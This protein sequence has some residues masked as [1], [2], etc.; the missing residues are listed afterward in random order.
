LDY[1]TFGHD[2]SYNGLEKRQV[3]MMKERE[4]T[5]TKISNDFL[6]IMIHILKTTPETLLGV[7]EHALKQLMIETGAN[8]VY[9]KTK[10]M[11]LSHSRTQFNPFVSDQ[12]TP[13]IQEIKSPVVYNLNDS[14]LN[15]LLPLVSDVMKQRYTESWA[16]IPFGE[17]CFLS[18]ESSSLFLED[19][20]VLMLGMYFV[21]A[22]ESKLKT[23]DLQHKIEKTI[24]AKSEF[25]ANMSHEIRTPLSGIYNAFYL[26]N[27][28]GLSHEQLEYVNNGMLSVD[29]LSSMIDDVLDYATIESGSMNVNPTLFDLE[30]EMVRIHQNYKSLSEDKK[31]N[32][33]FDFDYRLNNTWLGD[34]V[35]I[36][37][38]V[39]HLLDNAIKY[40]HTGEIELKI[41][42]K[43]EQE[44]LTWIMI[45]IR[46][47]GIG[48]PSEAL[49]RI[50]DAFVQLDSSESKSYQGTGLGLS[51]ATQLTFLLNGKIEVQSALNQGSQFDVSLPLIAQVQTLYPMTSGMKALVVS[52]NKKRS[53][54]TKALESMGITCFNLNNLHQH[55]VDFIVDED[56]QAQ[57]M[58]L[59]DLK[60][61][62]GKPSVLSLALFVDNQSQMKDIDIIFEW[63]ISRSSIQQKINNRFN[64][65]QKNLLEDNY[66][67]NLRGHA[68]L[69]DD[70]RLNRVALQSIL[71][72]QGIRSTSAD[73]GLKAIEIMKKESF[74]IIFMDIQMPHMDGLETTRR[75]RNLGTSYEK[76]PIIAITANQ[77]FKDY[78]L[79][80][81]T[82]INDVLFKPIRMD[83]LGQV[84]RKYIP[85]E[86]GIQIPDE[87]IV[88]DEIEFDDRFDGSD[89]IA[90]EVMET[91][92]DEYPKDL[93]NIRKSI[94]SGIAQQIYE[95]T[96][97][98]K[99]SCAY[100][101]GKRAVWLLNQMTTLSKKSK[102]ESM[103]MLFDLLEQEIEALI[104]S[105]RNK[106]V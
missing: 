71:L 10:D 36:R 12:I 20:E 15:Q 31:L 52:K 58:N 7:L 8:H 60:T 84:L 85:Q 24:T 61:K 78:D 64:Q 44:S 33:L 27:T 53:K 50:Q 68:L 96:H 38:I 98:F 41:S 95:T 92:I 75:I 55:R 5:Q 23:I 57:I 46:D 88:F 43:S 17:G 19:S 97:Y 69:V 40:T 22:L 106:L 67:Q 103:S 45:S 101:S 63:P 83:N 26:L 2:L 11:E 34:I 91:F 6:N 18:V 82:Q 32:L 79:M 51:I 9:L 65:I 66:D 76:V 35:K 1:S 100:L 86:R 81:S 99:G 30:H 89:D 70:N 4:M 62:Y 72:K 74:D 28:T 77:Y 94:A 42:K 59:K 48:I 56:N 87:L 49:H 90:L 25:L 54:L 3:S 21:S 13:I 104:K 80:K 16:M 102:L 39:H 73:S 29:Q 105:I 93:L 37:Q 47:T 14:K